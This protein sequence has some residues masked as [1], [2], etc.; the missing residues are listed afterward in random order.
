[1]IIAWHP[2]AFHDM[3]T[4]FRRPGNAT[5][6]FLC[7]FLALSSGYTPLAAQDTITSPPPGK[8]MSTLKIHS[9]KRASIYS[10]V[11]P[12][13]GQAYNH[14][15]WKIPIIYAG[16]GAFAYFINQNYTEYQKFKEA[17][18][19]KVSGDTIPIDNEYIYKYQTADQLKNGK[20]YYLRNFELTC[21]LT[22]VWYILNILD[23]TVDAHLMDYDINEDLS[24]HLQP[25]FSGQQ[26]APGKPVAGITM[27]LRFK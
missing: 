12:G 24:V 17:Y 21:I 9:P 14:K 6:F 20:D 4:C 22:G 16:F 5:I 27:A 7:L 23:A 1:M 8:D 18:L 26:V 11:L 2:V 3:R 10:A 25:G 15:Y 19:W 13:L